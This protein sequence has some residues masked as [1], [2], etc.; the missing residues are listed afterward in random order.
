MDEEDLCEVVEE[1]N[2]ENRPLSRGLTSLAWTLNYC[3]GFKPASN[4]SLSLICKSSEVPLLLDNQ[5]SHSEGNGL[6]G[7]SISSFW[8]SLYCL[9]LTVI[10]CK[11]SPFALDFCIS[12]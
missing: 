11:W 5:R 12:G 2:K 3:L 10:S 9:Q 7:G 8:P 6:A 1:L 4:F